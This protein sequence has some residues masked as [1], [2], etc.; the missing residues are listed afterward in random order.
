MSDRIRIGFHRLGLALALLPIVAGVVMMGM[1]AWAWVHPLAKPP[2]YEVKNPSGQVGTVIWGTDIRASVR[3]DFGADVPESFLQEVTTYVSRI[4]RSRRGRVV[5]IVRACFNGPGGGHLRGEL[6]RRVDHAG[7]HGHVNVVARGNVGN[8]RDRRSLRR[9]FCAKR[10]VT[11]PFDGSVH[12]FGGRI[13]NATGPLRLKR[14]LNETSP[15]ARREAQISGLV[16]LAWAK[17]LA[18]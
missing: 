10:P 14:M 9:N 18:G 3:R 12:E 8:Q 2:V 4:D 7:V 5:H 11:A 13:S 1:G 16:L 15:P 17:M 6:A